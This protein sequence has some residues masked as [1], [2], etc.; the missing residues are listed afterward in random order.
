MT[1]KKSL[2]A[3]IIA[4]MEEAIAFERGTLRGAEVRKVVTARKASVQ[5]APTFTRERI[6]KLRAALA[7]SQPVFAGAL[8]VSPDAVRSW[9]QG[10]RVPDGAAARLLQVAE[11]HPAWLL[12]KVR[13][14]TVKAK[15][16][17][18]V[19][20]LSQARAGVKR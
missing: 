18:T 13:A 11:E 16:P 8:N 17:A 3:Q 4:G 9:E 1:N 2:G 20:G 7:L 5:E 15:R 12:T 19:R 14:T 10:K 6:V